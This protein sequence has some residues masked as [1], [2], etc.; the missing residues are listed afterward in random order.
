VRGRWWGQPVAVGGGCAVVV[1]LVEL[2]DVEAPAWS[3]LSETCDAAM[4][5][6]SFPR[7]SHKRAERAVLSETHETQRGIKNRAAA[8]RGGT[9]YLDLDV[10][11]GKA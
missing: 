2:A 7:T 1:A 9:R 3:A 4:V 5:P 10:F 8:S 6:K 11:L